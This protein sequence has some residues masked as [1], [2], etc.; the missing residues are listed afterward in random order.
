MK[1]LLDDAVT[2]MVTKNFRPMAIV[3]DSGF[4]KLIKILDPKYVLPS[5]AKLRKE[6]IPNKSEE[7]K[8]KLKETLKQTDWVCISTDLWSSPRFDSFIGVLCHFYSPTEKTFKTKTLGCMKFN[9]HHTTEEIAKELKALFEEYDISDKI[10][11]IV[12][13]HASK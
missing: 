9:E 6:L 2:E 5:R 7:L 3:E 10:A 4:K 13:D 11:A 8:R 12:T 1:V